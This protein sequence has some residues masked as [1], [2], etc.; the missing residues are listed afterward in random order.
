MQLSHIATV[1]RCVPADLLRLLIS[2]LHCK[3]KPSQVLPP[4]PAPGMCVLRCCSTTATDRST[5][6]RSQEEGCDAVNR[7][8]SHN[9]LSDLRCRTPWLHYPPPAA[10]P[11]LRQHRQQLQHAAHCHAWVL[12]AELVHQPSQHAAFPPLPCRQVC[13]QCCYRQ[14]QLRAHC[15]RAGAESKQQLHEAVAQLRYC[16]CWQFFK[17]TLDLQEQER[18]AGK[19][20]V[21]LD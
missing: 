21:G 11:H 16:I 17:V 14:A 20:Q 10:F 3:C 18:Q 4:T 19:G 8:L 5:R 1:D 13:C 7:A 6:G 12:P 2:N 9:T 15:R